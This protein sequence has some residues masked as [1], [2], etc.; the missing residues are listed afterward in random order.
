MILRN[1]K[2]K[3]I[4]LFKKWLNKPYI[5][6]WYSPIDDWIKEVK[7]KN[8]EFDFIKHYIAEIDSTPIGF[9]QYYDVSKAGEDCFKDLPIDTF[10]IDYL[11]GEEK[12]LH[13]GNGKQIISLIIEKAKESGAKIIVVQPDKDN[14]KSRN[15]LLS[16][17]FDYDVSK[18]LFILKIEN[19][20]S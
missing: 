5:N 4:E 18:D 16:N 17:E 10:S 7:N 1:F 11:I 13:L 14:L 20:N 12:Y 2:E 3:D 8:G 15:A 9:C 19:D 6:K